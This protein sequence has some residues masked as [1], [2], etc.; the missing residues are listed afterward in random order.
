MMF[1]FSDCI[2]SLNHTII[3]VYKYTVTDWKRSTRKSQ[4][5][6]SCCSEKVLQTP[7]DFWTLSRALACHSCW[8]WGTLRCGSLW[9]DNRCRGTPKFVPVLFV[10]S[11]L[12]RRHLRR[13]LGCCWARDHTRYGR[14]PCNG[15]RWGHRCGWRWRPCLRIRCCS[16]GRRR[17]RQCRGFRCCSC[18]RRRQC[19]RIRC[20]SCGR[21]RWRQ[22]RSFR[23][24]CGRRQCLG[25]RCCS[26]GC[27]RQCLGF[28]CCSCGRQCLS[29]RCCSCLEH[30][31]WDLVGE[32]LFFQPHVK[33]D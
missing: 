9:R 19:L 25:F 5:C 3:P 23:C 13:C 11:L 10:S 15:S 27:R 17:W 22:C 20:C 28:R 12:S 6:T 8:R 31:R 1:L 30:C 33:V 26:C 24:C 21:R 4:P 32:L 14:W 18:G 2:V 16:C 29:C 7:F